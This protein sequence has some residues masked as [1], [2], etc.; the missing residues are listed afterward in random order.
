MQ[1]A[2]RI[3]FSYAFETEG[4]Q[5]HCGLRAHTLS[6]A[7]ETRLTPTETSAI[8]EIRSLSST[9]PMTNTAQIQTTL[10]M[11]RKVVVSN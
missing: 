8:L 7:M 11:G 4:R 9:R 10:L 3:P 5:I 1:Y 2:L 6:K